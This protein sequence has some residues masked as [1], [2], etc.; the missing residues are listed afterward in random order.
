MINSKEKKILVITE[1]FAPEEFLINDLVFFWRKQSLLVSVLTRNPSYP[2]EKMFPGYRNRLFQKEFINEVPIYRVQFIPG[3]KNNKL[4]KILNYLWNMFLGLLWA[5]KNGKKFD[6]IYIYQTGPLTFSSIGILIKKLYKKETTIWSQDVWPDTVFAYDL[7]KKGIS[8]IILEKF[9]EWVYSNCDNITVSCPG[10][11][12]IINKYCPSKIIHFIPQWSST[13]KLL[14]TDKQSLEIKYPGKFNFVFAG[15]IGKVQN[16]E[17]VISGF[18]QFLENTSNKE[19]WLNLIG[20]G[21]H[22]NFLQEKVK[23]NK[24]E[25]VKFWGRIKSSDMP[26]FYAKADVLII[27]LDNQPI[28]NLTIPAKFQSYLNAEKPIF[29]IIS[30]E[31]ANLIINNNL[32]WVASPDNITEIAR[33]FQE[34]VSSNS[35]VFIEKTRNTNILLE[36]QFNRE[37][38]IQRFTDLVFN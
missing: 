33:L 12:P 3:Y 31:V 29:G 25:N 30:G 27:S 23:S 13:S 8:R 35:D 36:E 26:W 22:L 1:V 7:A 18:E 10:F 5:L 17:N 32:G 21:S 4:I 19:V 20:D 28:F 34:I 14:N 37:K 24:I 9:V 16:L 2:E 15:N 38:I 6:S 11:I